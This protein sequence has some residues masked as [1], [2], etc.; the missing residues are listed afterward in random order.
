MRIGIIGGGQLGMM[1]TEA[2]IKGG[3]E[4]FVID[5][6][7]DAPAS[8]VGA[9]L[10][11]YDYDDEHGIDELTQCVDVICYEFENINLQVLYPYQHLI[12]Q[13]LKALEI[14]QQ[15]ILEK[16]FA[17]SLDI[18]IPHYQV[19]ETKEDLNDIVYPSILKTNRFGYDGK[20]QVLLTSKKDLEYIEIHQTMIL[21]EW[22]PFDREVSVIVTRDQYHH[23]AYYPIIENTHQSG[24]LDTSIPWWDAP[25]SW[26]NQAYAY[27][28][29]VV[30][31]LDYIG[32]LAIEFFI[33]GEK[34]IFNE[35]APRPHNSGHFSIEGTQTSQFENMIKAITHEHVVD[36]IMT[37]PSLMINVLGQHLNYYKRAQGE[38]VYVHDYYKNSQTRNRKIGHITCLAQTKEELHQWVK[39]IKGE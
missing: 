31:S 33:K 35:M 21:E 19:I 28:K 3:H 25:K 34:I 15:R 29:S 11:H 2:A 26:V 37:M 4:V 5:P 18:P 22:I 36:P 20:G 30:E 17:Q 23:I 16:K 38:N 9:H 14:S 8:H 12:P 39:F 32:T 13:G 10:L 24:I 6:N 27:A 1:L 7:R